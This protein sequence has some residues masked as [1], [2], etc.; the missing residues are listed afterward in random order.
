[1]I[2]KS[3]MP[4]SE[5]SIPSEGEALYVV[6]VNGGFTTRNN[7]QEGDRIVFEINS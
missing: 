7:I 2:Y 1:M 4:Y 6:E 3:V 5:K